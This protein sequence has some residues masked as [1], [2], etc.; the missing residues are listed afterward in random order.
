MFHE[1]FQQ[2]EFSTSIVITFQVMAVAGMSAGNPDCIGTFT[3]CHQKEFGAHPTR[4]WDSHHPDI[5]GILGTT[6]PG[7]VSGTIAAPVAQETDY[8]RFKIS[9]CI[10]SPYKIYRAR[11]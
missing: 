8:F 2:G 3:Q 10:L 6:H 5:G 7:K 9:H 11:P 1:V 4:A